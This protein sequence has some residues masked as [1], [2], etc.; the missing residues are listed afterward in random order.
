MAI[1]VRKIISGG[2]TGADQGG[3]LAARE[4]G[5]ATGGIAP[6]VWL[7][8]SGPQEE[9]LRGFGLAECE[10]EGYPARTRQN[11][12]LS[13]GTLLVGP[14]QSGGSKLTHEL[15]TQMSKPL[16][17]ITFPPDNNDDSQSIREFREWLENHGIQTL[18]VAG[19][20]E[21]QSPGIG[22]F[23]REFLLRAMQED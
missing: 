13:D 6:R 7:T 17:L 8:E 21:S 18:N 10:E 9:L 20:R 14:Y 1:R 16:F 5:I 22:E 23:T 2:Q 11:I 19:N 4:L 12:G 15:A 3:L